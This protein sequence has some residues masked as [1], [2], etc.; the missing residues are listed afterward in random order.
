MAESIVVG[1]YLI[2]KTIY[3][4]GNHGY[5]RGFIWKKD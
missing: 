3:L 1:L 5:L 4:L 2:W